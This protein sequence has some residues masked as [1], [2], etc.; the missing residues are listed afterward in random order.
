M[1]LRMSLRAAARI[2][3]AAELWAPWAA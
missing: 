2:K 1:A 3:E